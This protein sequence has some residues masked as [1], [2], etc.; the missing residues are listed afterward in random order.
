MQNDGH[1]IVLV[2]KKL[3]ADR[4]A[5]INSS[6]KSVKSSIPLHPVYSL[7]TD[8]VGDAA[9]LS[10]DGIVSLFDPSGTRRSQLVPIASQDWLV[11][12]D[13]G[14]F[15]GTP[16]AFKWASY[17][18]SPSSPPV[19]V[20]TL[21]NELYIPG[22]LPLLVAGQPPHLA[23]GLS[24]TTLLELP[25]T[26][27]LLQTAGARPMLLEGKAV[28][29]FDKEDIFQEFRQSPIAV[30]ADPA[31]PNCQ[32]RMVLSDQSNPQ[33][34]VNALKTIKNNQFVTPWDGQQVPIKGTVHLLTVAVG[35]YDHIDEPAIPTAVP[36]V[37]RLEALIRAQ[38]AG[39]KLEDWDHE[40]GGALHKAVATKSTILGCLDKMM[41]MV[42]PDDMVVL[43]FA[44]HGGSSTI[45][46]GQGEL[47]YFYP[48]DVKTSFDGLENAIS[49]AELAEKL[50][51]LQARRL[52]V[53]MDACDSG[54]MI[55]PLEGA[56]AAR[57]RDAIG[58]RTPGIAPPPQVASQGV[59][60]M[61][62]SAEVEQSITGATMNPFLDRLKDV[63]SPKTG[64]NAL[65]SDIAVKMTAPLQLKQ[66]DG[67]FITT[68]PVAI[69]IGADF[70]V[71][72]P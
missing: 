56:F 53:V 61:A 24:L 18:S 27:L 71:T 54:A 66:Q 41:A 39:E 37:E 45:G 40:C 70:A 58:S 2:I 50:R 31:H 17:R 72:K 12:S 28:V 46:T 32:N 7:T 67:S 1:T 20:D 5:W 65:A 69:H 23:D 64:Q 48:S 3:S 4:I 59:L 9:A 25:G 55:P 68:T 30:T 29:C 38:Y 11:F 21:F 51:Y 16:N 62:A 36:A 26:Q 8:G 63:L 49:S 60:L 10:N 47:F 22:L 19:P 33:S 6:A 35:E 42:K 13:T 34:T 52:V 15:D 44:G 57:L 14:F 43:I